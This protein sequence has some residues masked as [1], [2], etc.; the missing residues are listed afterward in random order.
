M[1]E[2]Y[3]TCSVLTIIS[4]ENAST[5]LTVGNISLTKYGHVYTCEIS[6]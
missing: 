2:V 1:R 4:G 5:H 6:R 3:C